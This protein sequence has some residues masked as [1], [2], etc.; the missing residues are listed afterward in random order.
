MNNGSI[1]NEQLAEVL[2]NLIKNAGITEA[3]LSRAINMPRATINRIKTGAI[4]DPKSSTLLLIADYFHI[5][6]D[7]LL[8]RAPIASYRAHNVKV[9]LV[10]LA[11]VNSFHSEFNISDSIRSKSWIDYEYKGNS[12]KLFAFKVFGDAMWPYFDDNAILI[13]DASLIPKSHSFVVVHLT[14][15][16]EI[17]VRKLL[18]D[19]KTMI[20][21]AIN[22]AFQNILLKKGDN[23]I[24]VLVHVK[25]DL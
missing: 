19:G 16:D 6:V 8:G 17:I 18:I 4:T 15:S 2:N 13:A 21:Q 14:Q 7:Q 24:G 3:Y 23:I 9:P 5:S 11:Q 12:E 22:N 10:D 20:L 1:L 25:K